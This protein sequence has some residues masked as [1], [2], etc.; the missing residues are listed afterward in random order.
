MIPTTFG[1]I[2][3]N[4]YINN[5][6]VVQKPWGKEVWLE[7]NDKYCYK[8][9]YINAG[10]KTSYQMHNYKLETNFI[11][12]GKAEVWLENDEGIV[13]KFIMNSGDYFT[14]LPPRKH[15]VIA[16]TDII[17]Q[18]VSTP[19]VDDV[20]RI[21][22]EFNRKDGKIDIEHVKPVVC[23]LAAG[24]GS[25]LGILS[26]TSHKSL[27][28]INQKAILNTIIDRFDNDHDI[29][30]AVGYLKEQ[31]KE[32]INIYYPDKNIKFVDVDP[33]EGNGSGTAYSTKCCKDYL[34]RP[35]YWTVCDNYIN[36][37]IQNLNLTNKNWISIKDTNCPELYSTIKVIDDKVIDIKDKC[38][39]GYSKAFTGIFYMHDYKLFWDQMEK[40]VDNTESIID[41]FK[42]IQLFNF[43]PKQI[44]LE[45]M[46]TSDL[47]NNLVK[48]YESKYLHLH[49]TKYEHK[50]KKDNI[51]I[52]AGETKKIDKLLLRS[53]H[54]EKYI[55]K[56]MFKGNYFFTYEYFKGKTLYELNDKT[57]YLKLLLVLHLEC[58]FFQF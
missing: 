10:F 22:D 36:D 33:Y 48:T 1:N 51:F 39:K 30:I 25:R 53:E 19:E 57:T 4:N 2:N 9:I 35:F 54:L 7:L 28:P 43:E 58:E 16:I 55:P 44:S 6:K 32:Y 15:R 18:E 49:K 46:G 8:R 14:V 26:K 42:N 29:I 37:E 3:N 11:I 56:L 40:N 31:V 13:E 50:Y 27:L 47:Y 17:L 24:L 12:K 21:N 20:I 5:Q 34:Q 38:T 45:D 41:V 23:I 52:K